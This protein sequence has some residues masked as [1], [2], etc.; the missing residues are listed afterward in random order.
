MSLN[1]SNFDSNL[2]FIGKGTTDLGAKFTDYNND[3][4][5]L[6]YLRHC[7]FST[8]RTEATEQRNF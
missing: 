1:W 8:S 4:R 3:K 7:A 2:D 5:H 6:D